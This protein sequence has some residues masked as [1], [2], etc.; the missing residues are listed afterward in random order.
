MFT[1]LYGLNP[2][3]LIEGIGCVHNDMFMI[4]FILLALYFL[5]KKKNILAS[6]VFL[7]LATA[8]KYFAIILLPFFVIYYFRKETPS[9]RL[10]RCFQCGI[11]YLAILLIPYLFYMQDLQV[12]SGIFTQQEKLA[13]SFYIIIKEY[14]IEPDISVTTVNQVLLGSFII[15]YFFTCVILLCKKQIKFHIEMKKANYFIIAFLFLLI[16]NFQPW[17][18]LWLF[19]LL[20]WQRAEDIRLIVQI[21]LISQFANSI[22]LT[23]GEGWKNGTPFAFFMVT[24]I[25]IAVLYNTRFKRLYKKEK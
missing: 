18:I 9:K 7:A 22:F 25:L 16:T 20:I 13:K 19:P 14:F 6:I 5:V 15:V 8:V 2:F 10:L 4:L 12:L 3:V 1:L 24:G 23:Y 11:F 17:Y 21:S